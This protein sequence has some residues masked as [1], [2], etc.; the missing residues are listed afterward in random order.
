VISDSVTRRIG[1]VRRAHRLSSVPLTSRAAPLEA[2]RL[3]RWLRESGHIRHWWYRTE[4]AERVRGILS[5]GRE[6]PAAHLPG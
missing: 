6:N 2:A 1:A 4:V 5:I 3:L